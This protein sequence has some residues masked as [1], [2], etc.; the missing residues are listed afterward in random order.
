MGIYSY[1]YSKKGDLVLIVE[2]KLLNEFNLP[3]SIGATKLLYTEIWS[4]VI[5]SCQ[6]NSEYRKDLYI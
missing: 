6:N 1:T 2:G 3:D 4:K 5:V